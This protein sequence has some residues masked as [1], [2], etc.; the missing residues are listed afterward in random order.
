M[1]AAQV[2]SMKSRNFDRDQLLVSSR[3][4]IGGERAVVGA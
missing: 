1:A 2:G 3:Q 4:A